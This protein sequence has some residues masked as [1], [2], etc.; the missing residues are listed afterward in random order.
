MKEHRVGSIVGKLV[1]TGLLA[2]VALV[3]GVIGWLYLGMMF[4]TSPIVYVLGVGYGLLVLYLF[5]DIWSMPHAQKWKNLFL[6]L[7]GAVV[8]VA[9]SC[10]AYMVYIDCIPT[11]KDTF[12]LN[13]YQ[14]YSGERVATLNM[15]PDLQLTSDLPVIDCAT[16]L[17]PVASA[18]V[19]ATYPAGEYPR[20]DSSSD[21]S[22]LVYCSGTRGAYENLI[23][24]NVD[25]IIVAGPS[26]DQLRQMEEAGVQVTMTPIGREAFVF[27]VNSKNPVT[28]LT[29]EEIQGIYSG[30]I[31]NWQ[32]V[33]GENTAIR[34]F[35]RNE[36]SG[37]QTALQQL[38]EG[39][40]LMKPPTEDVVGA[41][42]GIIEWVSD[43]KNYKNAI[44]FSFR[45]YSTEMVEDDEIRLLKINGVE[46][47]EETIRDDTYP[48][49]SEFYAITRDDNENANVQALLAWILSPQGQSLVEETGYVGV[50]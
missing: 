13:Q 6:G 28:G 49:T 27:F 36:N 5:I 50:Q 10:F 21:N 33:G 38:M 16:A 46:P 24:G 20:Y 41:M 4:G 29:L 8:I 44:G 1:F 31:T 37:S 26:G 25:M 43:Y 47:N 11:V 40:E 18:F 17:Y 12:S 7:E 39:R 2:Y 15:P 22:I 45:F 42:S 34:A 19:Q 23:E 14:A 32:E 48:I 3:V 35:Q 30:Q 9:L